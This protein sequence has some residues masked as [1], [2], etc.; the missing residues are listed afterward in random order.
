MQRITFDTFVHLFTG[1]KDLRDLSGKLLG[2]LCV[3]S[4]SILRDLKKFIL[5]PL[6]KNNI[7]F[8]IQSFKGIK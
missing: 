5:F 8:H 6:R 7:Y 3:P 4:Y 2:F 1:S